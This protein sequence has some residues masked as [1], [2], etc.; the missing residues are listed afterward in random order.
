MKNKLYLLGLLL[1]ILASCIA[2]DEDDIIVPNPEGTIDLSM[3]NDNKNS[4]LDG[5]MYIDED[6]NFIASNKD[7]YIVPVG[8]VRGLGN[9]SMIPKSG[10][11]KKVAVIQGSGYVV[12]HGSQFYRLFVKEYS[13]DTS[14]EIIGANLQYQTPFIGAGSD[15]KLDA[16][17]VAFMPSPTQSVDISLDHSK[18]EPFDI[19]FLSAG[20]GWCSAYLKP[21]LD[22]NTLAM[23][24]IISVEPYLAIKK[25]N[26]TNRETTITIRSLTK[27]EKKVKVIQEGIEPYIKLSWNGISSPIYYQAKKESYS[28]WIETNLPF[29]DWNVKTDN[30][31]WLNVVKSFTA[32]NLN[33]ITI[34]IDIAANSSRESREGKLFLYSTDYGIND[35]IRIIQMA[36]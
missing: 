26:N 28:I 18:I 34:N 31:A 21:V 24:L 17:S 19:T 36:Y 27:T 35:T 9:V 6:N 11:F 20:I 29:D 15:I 5:F 25:P 32:N 30:E 2:E 7:T 10:W 1:S 33:D 22:T 13:L 23:H 16:D 14:N 12:C 4:S 8:T 3:R